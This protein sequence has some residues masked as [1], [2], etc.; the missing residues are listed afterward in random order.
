MLK[1]SSLLYA[2]FVC[3]IVSLLC[4]SLIFIS[5]S[6]LQLRDYYFMQEELIDVANNDFVKVISEQGNNQQGAMGNYSSKDE[7]FNTTYSI[8]KWGFYNLVK[9]ATSFKKDTV[10]K[11]ALSGGIAKKSKLALYVVERDKS[12]NIGG[13]TEIIGDAMIS[14]RGAVPTYVD[15][16]TIVK[17][18]LIDGNVYTSERELPKLQES[19]TENINQSGTAVLLE[20]LSGRSISNSFHKQS[21]IVHT[22]ALL[23]VDNITLSG[24]VVIVSKD[25]ITIKKTAILKD[26]L[27]QAPSVTFETG[28]RGSVQVFSKKGVYLQQGAELLYPSSIYI[29]NDTTDKVDVVLE[30]KS[31]I[32]GGIVLTGDSYES[33]LNKLVT[34]NENALV[35]G[36]V[37]CYGKTQLKGKVIGTI[38]TTLFYLKTTSSIYENYILGG[39]VNR[40]DLPVNFIGLPLFDHKNTSYAVV[41]EL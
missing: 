36:D 17:S 23:S 6:Q 26:V 15:N 2:I 18:K 34:I 31:K 10:Y 13:K 11:A 7:R 12:L 8:T 37:Y 5:T 19:V 30:E 32:G 16:Q 14:S 3:M 9:T 28:F 24:N 29:K 22:G 4:G 35:V 1:A 41:K 38:Y 40:L 20:D 39:V 33:S 25:S 21:L 27:I